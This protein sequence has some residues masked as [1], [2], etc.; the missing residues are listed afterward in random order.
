MLR[1]I[2]EHFSPDHY[3][4]FALEMAVLIKQ[5]REKHRFLCVTALRGRSGWCAWFDTMVWYVDL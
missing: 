2:L 5:V 4:P 3:A 1:L